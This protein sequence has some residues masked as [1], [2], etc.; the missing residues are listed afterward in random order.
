MNIFQKNLAATLK[1]FGLRSRWLATE[2]GTDEGSISKY[3]GGKRDIYTSTLEKW[4]G[5]L[6]AEAQEYFLEAC[7][8]KKIVMRERSLT[9]MIERLDPEKESDRKQ[10]ADAMRL[11]AAKFLNP[12][13]D[14]D[15]LNPREFTD[16]GRQMSLL[17][18]P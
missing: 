8:E 2:T 5:A 10:A 18:S 17:K 7:L 13:T 1:R 16:E 3:I 14:R 15:S 4:Y 12:S 9:E 6:P 11:I